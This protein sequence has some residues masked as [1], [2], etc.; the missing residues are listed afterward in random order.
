MATL[1]T[2][3]GISVEGSVIAERQD[4]NSI[5]YHSDVSVKSLLSGAV[6]RPEWAQPLYQTLDSC[7]K[8]RGGQR[9]W[10]DDSPAQEQEYAFTGHSTPGGEQQPRMLQKKK[11]S[12]PPPFPP[13]TWGEQKTA[14]SY[15]HD[16][17]SSPT[18]RETSKPAWEFAN[19][20]TK[21]ATSLFETHFDSDFNPQDDRSRQTHIRG[22]SLNA[23]PTPKPRGSFGTDSG[24][25]YASDDDSPGPN[26]SRA[27]TYG[28]PYSSYNR[29]GN[30]SRGPTMPVPY[31]DPSPTSRSPFDSE[32]EGQLFDEPAPM[33]ARPVIT[34]KAELTA[35]LTPG[36][37]V[38]RAIALFDFDAVEVRNHPLR[39]RPPAH[40]V[41]INYHSLGMS[42]SPRG[43]SSRSP[44]RQELRIRG[45]YSNPFGSAPTTLL[46][47]L[48]GGLGRSTVDLER[49]P[50]ILSRL[51]ERRGS[52]D[53]SARVLD[54][55]HNLGLDDLLHFPCCKKYLRRSPAVYLISLRYAMQICNIIQ[56][57]LQYQWS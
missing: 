28:T 20:D 31:A 32:L 19:Q 26:L 36:E 49:S 39:L 10:I 21:H 8:F 6:P 38:G 11:K 7:T 5:A 29:S 35:P 18:T 17:G 33:S 51:F 30:V 22:F 40:V 55:V 46:E 27:N 12:G 23:I 54:I 25:L 56:R 2:V 15:F 57:N 1:I 3:L 14:G 42:R 45:T 53:A 24:G 47:C 44:R 34:P 16:P 50:P 52:V 43:R 48:L 4:A 9:E 37:G 13:S 41:H